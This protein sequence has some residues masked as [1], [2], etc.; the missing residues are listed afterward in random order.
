MITDVSNSMGPN[1]WHLWLFLLD[2]VP[3]VVQSFFTRDDFTQ[4]V[5]TL[6]SA[7]GDEI[8]LGWE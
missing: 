8:F 5:L 4:K 6:I 3:Q 1:F 7:H 2:N